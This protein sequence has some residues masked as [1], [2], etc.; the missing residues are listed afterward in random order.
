MKTSSSTIL[1]M[2]YSQSDDDGDGHG[3]GDDDDDGPGSI[4]WKGSSSLNQGSAIHWEG[5]VC[6]L[7]RLDI[8]PH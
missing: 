6:T 4:H 5:M 8:W 2:G 1:S 3:G 7:P